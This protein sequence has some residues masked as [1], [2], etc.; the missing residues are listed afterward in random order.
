[1]EEKEINQDRVEELEKM[2]WNKIT[3]EEVEETL[4][5]HYGDKIADEYTKLRGDE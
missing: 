4:R 2:A 3:G 5:A 1:M